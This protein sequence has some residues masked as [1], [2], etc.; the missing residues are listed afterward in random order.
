LPLPNVIEQTEAVKPFPA[1]KK[2]PQKTKK[3]ADVAA[4]KAKE[5]DKFSW[6]SIK[7]SIMQGQKKECTQAESALNQCR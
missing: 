3:S 2:A 4:K 1:K 6:E 7:K 5:N